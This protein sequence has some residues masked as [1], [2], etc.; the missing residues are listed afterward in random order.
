MPL[1]IGR[2]LAALRKAGLR[3]A[4]GKLAVSFGQAPH[5]DAAQV[6]ASHPE[7]GSLA[8]RLVFKLL[9]AEDGGTAGRAARPT[10]QS[11]CERHLFTRS[12][13]LHR[14]ATQDWS[15]GRPSVLPVAAL[16]E[17]LL[18]PPPAVSP[19]PTRLEASPRRPSPFHSADAKASSNHER[20]AQSRCQ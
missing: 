3:G 1:G 17:V 2:L 15:E 16:A 10:K 12:L 8:V 6:D 19:N 13:P 11:N 14:F 5:A 9:S 18:L 20:D 4:E 7:L